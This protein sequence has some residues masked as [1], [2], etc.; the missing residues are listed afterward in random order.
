MRL[1]TFI[2]AAALATTASYA[3]ADHLN[4]VLGGAIGGATGV[5]VGQSVGGRDGAI[6]G[7]A[8]GAATGV[9]LSNPRE[10]V[11]VR[12]PRPEPVVYAVPVEPRPVYVVRPEYRRHGWEGHG[13]REHGWKEH[14]R[15]G[16]HGRGHWDD[17]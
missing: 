14:G 6:V 10:R 5:L 9:I 4:S 13:W 1:T 11:V 8:I 16:E 15:W 7:G 2:T 17:D 3:M 12:E